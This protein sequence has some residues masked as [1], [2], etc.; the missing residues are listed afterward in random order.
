MWITR[1]AI[2]HPV[3]ATMVMV[4]LAVC[5]IFSAMQLGTEAMPDIKLPVVTVSVAYPGASPEQA[6]SDIAKPL[7]TT[8]NTIGGVKT[9]R[10]LS[11]AG[12]NL[13]IIEFRLDTEMLRAVQEVR[14][15][16][17]QV[18]PGFPREVREPVVARVDGDNDQPISMFALSANLRTPRE[19]SD[20]AKRVVQKRFERVPGVGRVDV[21]GVVQRQVEIRVQPDRLAALGITVD[22]V[23]SGLRAQ[24]VSVPVGRVSDDQSEVVVQVDGRLRSP[25][26]FANVIISHKGMVSVRLGQVATVVDA[27]REPDSLSR[28]NGQT[29]VSLFVYKAQDANTVQTGRE[30]K[31][32]VEELRTKDLPVG[33]DLRVLYATSDWIEQS[34]D[35]VRHTIVEGGVLTVLIVFLFL[36]SWRSTVITGLTLPIAVIATLTAIYAMGFTLNYMTLMALS[37]CIGLLIDDAIVVRENIVR[38]LHLGK[39]PAVAARDGTEEVG[40]AV[41]ATTLTIVAVFVPI[42]FMKGIIGKFFFAFGITVAVSVL[43]SLFISFT[44][45]PMLSAVW[46]DPHHQ[47][48]C[49]RPM[50]RWLD[51][52]ETG[53]ERLRAVYSRLLGWALRRRKTTLA[54]ASASFLVSI[55]LLGVVG[56]EFTPKTDNAYLSVDLSTPVGYSLMHT[57]ELVKEVEGRLRDFPEIETL[58]T[59]VGTDKG[60]NSAHLDLSLLPPAKRIRSQTQLETVVRERLSGMA[61]I[62]VVVGGGDFNGPPILINVMGNS[63]SGLTTAV[64]QI[65]DALGKIKGVRDIDVTLKEGTPTVAVRMKSDQAGEVGM[66]HSQLGESLRTMVDGENSGYW[67]SPDGQNVEVITRM[68]AALRSTTQD[69]T[70][71]GLVTGRSLPGGNPEILP[72]SALADVEPVFSPE[73]IRR[74]NLQRRVAILTNVEGRAAGD[75]GKDV[76]E[77]LKGLSL[78]AGITYRMNGELERQE[79][80]GGAMLQVLFLSV[81][82]IYIVLASQFGS[83]FQPLAIMTSLPLSIV[84][85]VLALLITHTTVNIFSMIGVVF[86][87][88]LVTKNAILLV[89]FANRAQKAGATLVDA[90]MQ[91]GQT[92]LRPILMTTAAMIFGMLPLSM[93]LGQGAEEQA[94]MGRA[95]IGGVITSTLLTLV[96]V[97]VIYSYISAWEQRWRRRSG[98][99]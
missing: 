15:K 10:S 92:R 41:L 31:E 40:L 77:A 39:A 58:S 18:R 87:M 72:L 34:I 76:A 83:F 70:R 6:E 36:G 68:P 49:R 11:S 81:I 54:M 98:L 37:L 42:A 67:L 3:F 63:D 38:H 19:L 91:A 95:I 20:L 4:A 86:L 61:G 33:V 7:E 82:F 62:K 66:T 64:G 29:A 93:G 2:G 85:V 46:N 90:L 8:L 5:G 30:L 89:D 53:F 75:V 12:Q 24:N 26:D 84:G 27:E 13:T 57:D 32:A 97:P 74:Q 25:A 23:V 59:R 96:V 48:G 80:T 17:A 60:H 45:D 35:N 78:P 43:L 94:P 52:F 47:P 16:V 9:V 88:G 71:M 1:T 21:A 65:R 50:G 22:Q 69:I 51:R 79:E 14:D 44:L 55:P 28:V 73:T 56:T 99:Q